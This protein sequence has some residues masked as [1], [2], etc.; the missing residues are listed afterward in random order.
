MPLYTNTTAGTVSYTSNDIGY[1][2]ILENDTAPHA[3]NNNTIAT[4][5]DFTFP[6]GKHER[7][8]GELGIWYFAHS[9][10]DFKYKI[11]VPTGGTLRWARFG[12]PVDDSTSNDIRQDTTTTGE[13]AVTTSNNSAYA[14]FLKFNFTV[15]NSTTAGDFSFQ[16]APNTAADDTAEEVYLK[17]GSYLKY[18][19]F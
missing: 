19:R 8:I 12:L 10:K 17:S 18:N 7:F 11:N 13:L 1:Q 14:G 6:V 9:D 2:A 15:V 16:W 4:Q 5:S 3:N